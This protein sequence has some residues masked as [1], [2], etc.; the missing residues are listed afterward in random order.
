[1]FCFNGYP[2]GPFSGDFFKIQ[3]MRHRRLRK[4]VKRTLYLLLFLFLAGITAWVMLRWPESP[5]A[6]LKKAS[7]AIVE[8]RNAEADKYAPRQLKKTTALYDSA[9]THW[10]KENRKFLLNRN[11]GKT[12][13]F[14]AQAVQAGRQTKVAAAEKAQSALLSTKVTTGEL[15]KIVADFKRNYSPLPLPKKI[16]EDFNKGI[17]MLSEAKLASEKSDFHIA[18]VKLEEAKKLLIGA[19]QKVHHILNDYFSALPQWTSQ[20]KEAINRS[21]SQ[22]SSVIIVDKMARE[23]RLYSDGKLRHTFE[24]EFGPNWMGDKMHRGDQATP[25]GEYHVVQKKEGRKTIYYKALL[26]NYPNV[27]DKARY[28]KNIASGKISSRV[29]VGGLIEIHG[30]GG[31]GFDWTNGCVALRNKDMDVLYRMVSEKTPVIIVGSVEPIDKY[32]QNGREEQVRD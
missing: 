20:V 27:E 19:D 22:N 7:D 31:Q 18:E 3:V 16:R 24:A 9:M 23:C 13:E 12:L 29:D 4:E 5:A 17:L 26:L 28:R 21:A 11:Y 8:A 25:E 6:E 15:E 2:R 1:M 32:I 14:A 30:H 10:R